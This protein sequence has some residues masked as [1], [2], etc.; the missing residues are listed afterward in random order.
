LSPCTHIVLNG[1]KRLS[2]AKAQVLYLHQTGYQAPAKR[3]DVWVV[4]QPG[5]AVLDHMAYVLQQGNFAS[6]YDRY[7][8]GQLAYILTGGD[9]TGPALVSEDYLLNL[10]RQIF[11]IFGCLISVKDIRLIQF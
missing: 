10:E 1:E 3:N 6:A 2:I 4:G 5:R 11:L 9:L 8:A 7:L